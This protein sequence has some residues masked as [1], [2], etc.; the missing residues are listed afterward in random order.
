MR[1][2]YPEA[3]RSLVLQVATVSWPA[4]CSLPQEIKSS[5]PYKKVPSTGSGIGYERK[6]REA[7]LDP[8]ENFHLCYGEADWLR[9]MALESQNDI[10]IQF[11]TDALRLLENLKPLVIE[12]AQVIESEYQL[13]NLESDIKADF[14]NWVLRFLHYFPGAGVGNSLGDQHVDKCGFT[15]HLQ[16]SG[17]GVDQLTYDGEWTPMTVSETETVIIPGMRLQYRSQCKLKAAC[18]RIVADENTATSGRFSAVCF[19]TIANTPVVDKEKAGRMQDQ[20]AGFNY[21]LPFEEL[22]TM[23]A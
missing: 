4:Y 15:L 2:S 9:K 20:K 13:Q 10:V 11:V 14:D 16:E 7:G 17:P 5:F 6:T 1:T 3:V 18:H 8:K 23:F 22:K 21:T 19:V 12:Q